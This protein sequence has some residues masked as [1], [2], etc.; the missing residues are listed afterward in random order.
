MTA[1]LS[2]E[3]KLEEIAVQD[4]RFHASAYRFIFDSLDYILVHMGRYNRPIGDR[5]ISVDQL[6]DGLKAYAIEQFGPLSRLVLESWGVYRTEDIGEIVFN[7]VEGGLLNK[8]DCDLKEDF[9]D[10][11]DFRKEFEENY[12]P[13]MPWETSENQ[14]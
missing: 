13:H 8:Q 9:T 10:G 2:L 6:L 14:N 12:I 11:F 1:T 3:D 7:L 4:G 5:H